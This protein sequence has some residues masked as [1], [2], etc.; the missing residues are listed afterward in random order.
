[1]ASTE[2]ETNTLAYLC[3][4]SVTNK[5]SF[6]TL[7]P[8]ARLT[9]LTDAIHASDVIIVAVSK[10]YYKVRRVQCENERTVTFVRTTLHR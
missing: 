2:K 1:M 6:M 3:G 9:N 5:K 8:G 4:T 10:E 7:A